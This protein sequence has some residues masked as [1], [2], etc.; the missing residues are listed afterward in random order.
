MRTNEIF[1]GF[2]LVGGHVVFHVALLLA[3]LF[4]IRYPEATDL[5]KRYLD[6]I[7]MF[8]YA[9]GANLFYQLVEYILSSKENFKKYMF[10][11]KLL[12]TAS[13]II[14]FYVA[15]YA[16]WGISKYDLADGE[17]VGQKLL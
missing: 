4:V 5:N 11:E 10:T 2:I 13:D 7:E 8:R 9:H 6:F 1:Q 16:L 14:Y 12:E 3:S 17:L 15:M